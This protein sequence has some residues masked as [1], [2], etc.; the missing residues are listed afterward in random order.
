MNTIYEATC[1]DGS[2]QLISPATFRHIYRSC[3]ALPIRKRAEAFNRT[4]AIKAYFNRWREIVL[5]RYDGEGNQERHLMMSAT[6]TT[7]N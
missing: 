7:N 1:F 3:E 5:I 2:R 6:I 4:V